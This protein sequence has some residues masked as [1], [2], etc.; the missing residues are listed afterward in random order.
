ML[1]EKI[2]KSLAGLNKE[3]TLSL[4]VQAILEGETSQEIVLHGLFAGLDEVAKRYEKKQHLYPDMYKASIIFH[5][6]LAKIKHQIVSLETKPEVRGAIGLVYGD[7]QDFGKNIV[8]MT[9]EANG[10]DVEDLGK[11]VPQETFLHAVQ[12]G[13]DFIGISIMTDEGVQEAKK[14]VQGLKDAG[15]RE[16]VKVIVGGAGVNAPIAAEIIEADGYAEDA[17]EVVEFLKIFFRV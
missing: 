2:A 11:S 1:L 8:H 14:V 6:A 3:E 12:E 4:T 15:I 17:G 5:E 16:Q 10:F 9:L 7:R 13:A